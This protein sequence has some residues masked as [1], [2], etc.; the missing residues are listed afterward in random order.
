MERA[1]E[2]ELF[3]QV[4]RESKKETMMSKFTVK[5]INSRYSKNNPN[6]LKSL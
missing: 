4:V 6:N 2:G 1:P 5:S 3:D